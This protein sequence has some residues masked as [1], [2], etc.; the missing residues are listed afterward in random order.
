M[1]R[2]HL[3]DNERILLEDVSSLQDLAYQYLEDALYGVAG[4]RSGLLTDPVFT[5]SATTITARVE[6]CGVSYQ[7]LPK[8]P[9]LSAMRLQ[10][11]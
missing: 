6:Y 8:C 2:T 9:P 1:E 11:S 10:E 5:V 7:K 3:I 4:T